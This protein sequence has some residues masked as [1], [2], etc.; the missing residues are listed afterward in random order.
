MGTRLIRRATRTDFGPHSL[1]D[2]CQEKLAVPRT[3]LSREREK[4]NIQ[5]KKEK[6]KNAF[7]IAR[8]CARSFGNERTLI[9]RPFSVALLQNRTLFARCLAMGDRLSPRDVALKLA[10]DVRPGGR[11]AS[12]GYTVKVSSLRGH[13]E[14]AECFEE[15]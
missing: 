10:L 8:R 9:G 5:K 2:D 1:F 15:P 14:F 6:N 3:V 12:G 13:E 7:L 11:W 4:K